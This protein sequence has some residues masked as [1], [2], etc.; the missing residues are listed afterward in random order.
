MQSPPSGLFNPLAPYL[1]DLL[2]LVTASMARIPQCALFA[3]RELSHE[4]RLKNAVT[5]VL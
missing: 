3:L 1:S 4:E 5:F 2:L